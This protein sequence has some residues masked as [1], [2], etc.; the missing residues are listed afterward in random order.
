MIIIVAWKLS[1]FLLQRFKD[2]L[3]GEELNVPGIDAGALTE[4]ESLMGYCLQP[5]KS[6]YLRAVVSQQNSSQL[7]P[8][9]RDL[10]ENHPLT[11]RQ[12][13]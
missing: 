5:S 12:S 3:G 7:L 9:E 4:D 8:T 11:W 2:N 10:V 6:L 1:T 13:W